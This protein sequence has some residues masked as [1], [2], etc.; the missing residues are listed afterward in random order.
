MILLASKAK[1]FVQD[2]FFSWAHNQELEIADQ[3]IKAVSN[4]VKSK[5]SSG[6]VKNIDVADAD[7]FSDKDILDVTENSITSNNVWLVEKVVNIGADIKNFVAGKIPKSAFIESMA[8]NVSGFVSKIV[9][10]ITIF[11]AGLMGTPFGISFEWMDWLGTVAGA[12]ASKVFCAVFDPL[13]KHFRKQEAKKEFEFLHNFYEASII[14]MQNQREI[15]EIATAKL[16]ENRQNL[17]DSCLKKLDDSFNSKDA[18]ELS[19]SLEKI[20]ESF[21]GELK[22]KNLDEFDN[23]MLNSDDELI[24]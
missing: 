2:Q 16:F 1:K 4:K 20:V 17:I 5:F 21:G 11:T 23:F 19:K 7:N 18:D 15:F 24:L 9:K 22:F 12:V 13:V 8:N 3:T 14:E 6:D 10:G